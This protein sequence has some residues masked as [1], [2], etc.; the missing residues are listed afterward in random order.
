MNKRLD[1]IM[2]AMKL[3]TEKDIQATPMS[4]IAKEAKTGMGTIYNY[5]ATKEELINAIYVH[6]KEEQ[7]AAFKTL[8]TDKGVHAQFDI[9]LE[10]MI[11]Y[12]IA[13]PLHFYFIEQ[14]KNSPLLTAESF[15]WTMKPYEPLIA[16]I[17]KGQKKGSIKPGPINDILYFLDGALN[18]FIG[19]SIVDNKV[20][21]KALENH[22]TMAW[23]AIAK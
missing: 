7:I 2:A 11:S 4:A 3:F 19:A 17:S 12:F 21:K 13:S 15:E 14:F 18:S 1:I 8:V 22:L 16:C 10:G 20:K 6:I 9:F 5:F 23:N